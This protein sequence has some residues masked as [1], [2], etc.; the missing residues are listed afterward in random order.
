MSFGGVTEFLSQDTGAAN[1]CADSV[2][3]GWDNSASLR[4]PS[5]FSNDFGPS[6]LL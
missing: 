4:F 1:N 2:N 5:I 3:L 6:A